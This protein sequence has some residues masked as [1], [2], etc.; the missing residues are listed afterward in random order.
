ME[1]ILGFFLCL[2][3][4]A[5]KKFEYV[6]SCH[7]LSHWQCQYLTT[8]GGVWSSFESRKSGLKFFLTIICILVLNLCAF[9]FIFHIVFLFMHFLHCAYTCLVLKVILH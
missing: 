4:Q 8:F 6:L 5:T 1:L 2:F 7:K 3:L 9:V